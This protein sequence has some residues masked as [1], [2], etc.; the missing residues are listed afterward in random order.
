MA[1][2]EDLKEQLQEWIELGDHLIVGKDANESVLH[3]S[4][5]SVFQETGLINSV[6]SIHPSQKAPTMFHQNSSNKVID[7]MWSTPGI[8]IQRGGCLEPKDAPGD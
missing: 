1:F 7:G 2:C 4:I 6:L 8:Q 5:A 3:T